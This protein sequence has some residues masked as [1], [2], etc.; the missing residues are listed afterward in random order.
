M[1]RTLGRPYGDY[2]VL[3]ELQNSRPSHA[4]AIRPAEMLRVRAVEN[5]NRSWQ[6][7]KARTR[8]PHMIMMA[9]GKTVDM[10]PIASMW[11]DA[12][13][14]LCA[15]RELQIIGYSLPEDD[16][17]IRTLLR[18]GVARGKQ[19]PRVI[20]HNPEPG[21]HVRVRTYVLRTAASDFSSFTVPV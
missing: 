19:R 18:A 20:V 14:A 5:M 10:T 2:A 7:I 8:R 17:E 15:A 3:R 9:Q 12:Y 1:F 11:G 13:R 4:L 21:V 6:F 16:V